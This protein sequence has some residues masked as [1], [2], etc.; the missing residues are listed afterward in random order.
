MCRRRWRRRSREGGENVCSV[1]RAPA[2]SIAKTVP[3]GIS[4]GASRPAASGCPIELAVACLDHAVWPS[5]RD[6]EARDD[7]VRRSLLRADCRRHGD[8]HCYCGD[9]ETNEPVGQRSDPH[10]RQLQKT[11]SDPVGRLRL[12]RCSP[13]RAEEAFTVRQRSRASLA[14]AIVV[15]AVRRRKL[16]RFISFV[17]WTEAPAERAPDRSLNALSDD[18]RSNRMGHWMDRPRTND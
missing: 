15:S 16:S 2:A 6:L 5:L 14:A 3:V 13:R 11:D 18:T 9:D 8:C 7:L 10:D 4:G 12:V 1:V 17:S